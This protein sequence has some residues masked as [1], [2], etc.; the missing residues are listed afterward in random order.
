MEGIFSASITASKGNE[1]SRAEE[2]RGE[3]KC[4]MVRDGGHVQCVHHSV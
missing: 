4:S 1:E 2:R 3:M